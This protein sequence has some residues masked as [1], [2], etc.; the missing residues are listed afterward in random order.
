MVTPCDVMED[1]KKLA[2]IH[3]AE[4][5]GNAQAA[6]QHPGIILFRQLNHLL[7]ILSQFFQGQ[8]AQSVIA[9]QFD[10]DDV[11]PVLFECLWQAGQAVTGG[12]AADACIDNLVWVACFP[13][14]GLQQ[15]HPAGMPFDTK[16]SAEAVTEHED[17]RRLCMARCGTA[18]AGN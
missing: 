11:R 15:L 3:R 1:F 6:Q 4:V 5:R 16:C 7:Q 2:A 17:D 8:A 10:N 12:V 18:Q 14:A 9:T 13:Q